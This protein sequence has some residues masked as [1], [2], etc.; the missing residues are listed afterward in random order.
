[1][2]LRTGGGS[3]LPNGRVKLGSSVPWEHRGWE[4]NVLCWLEEHTGRRKRA[5]VTQS[6]PSCYL[7]EEGYSF[8]VPRHGAAAMQHRAGARDLPRKE[9]TTGTARQN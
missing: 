4:K 2:G 3:P 6:A 1:M 9:G 5:V 8:H 7:W